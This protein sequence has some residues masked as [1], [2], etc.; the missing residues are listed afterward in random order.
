M[1]RRHRSSDRSHHSTP[2]D[3]RARGR[4]QST[5]T[6]RNDKDHKAHIEDRPMSKPDGTRGKLPQK[7]L[8]D[9][10][11]GDNDYVRRW[12]VQTD[13]EANQKRSDSHVARQKNPS[14]YP[15][16]APLIGTAAADT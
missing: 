16:W 3:S 10:L 7:I 12:L 4:R 14:Q 1:E 13:E 5:T 6:S 8:A 2:N 11:S 15:F 9:Q